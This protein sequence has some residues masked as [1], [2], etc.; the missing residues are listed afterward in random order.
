MFPIKTYFEY[1]NVNL[2]DR[3][4]NFFNLIF[5][6]EKLKIISTLKYS[7]TFG[8]LNHYLRLIEYLR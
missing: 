2:F 3:K 8:K 4:V 1:S 7:Y 5:L 6:K